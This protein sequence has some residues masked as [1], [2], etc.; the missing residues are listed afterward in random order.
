MAK[1]VIFGGEGRKASYRLLT[2]RDT[3]KLTTAGDALWSIVTVFPFPG[4]CEP[5]SPLLSSPMLCQIVIFGRKEVK[6]PTAR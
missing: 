1:I 5:Y 6:H 4:V 2:V 3:V